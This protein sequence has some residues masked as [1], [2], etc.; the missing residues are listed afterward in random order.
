MCMQKPSASRPNWH[1][2]A[3][4]AWQAWH[5][6]CKAAANGPMKTASHEVRT[7][8]ARLRF[9]RL[10][11]FRA[12]TKSSCDKPKVLMDRSCWKGPAETASQASCPMDL[13][14]ALAAFLIGHRWS[15]LG[16]TH[17]T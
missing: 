17:L 7:H 2:C 9:T 6:V 12:P 4:S 5:A 13:A 15:V 8:L 1:K 14:G 16:T 10:F 11:L 3:A